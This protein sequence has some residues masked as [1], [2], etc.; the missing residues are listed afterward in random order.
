MVTVDALPDT[1]DT[2][3]VMP[4]GTVVGVVPAELVYQVVV[5]GIPTA[6]FAVVTAKVTDPAN[7]PIIGSDWV[8]RLTVILAGITVAS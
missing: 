7:P 3:G 4:V 8:A 1:L 2:I 6:M 5:P